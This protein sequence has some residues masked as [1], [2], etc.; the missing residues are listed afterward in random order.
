[1]PRIIAFLL[2]PF[3]FTACQPGSTAEDQA[4]EIDGAGVA[5]ANPPAEGFNEAAS[6]EKAMAI[7]DSVMQ[8]M[9]G[10]K[11]WDTTQY[12]SWNFFDIRTL[13]W[14]KQSGDVRIEVPRDSA[15]YLINVNSDQ[16]K[17]A[18]GG[19]EITNADSLAKYVE[20]GKSI[21]INDSYWLFMPFKLKDSGVTLTYVGEDTIQG[22]D[23]AEVLELRFEGVGVTPQNKYQVYVDPND[24]MVTQWAFYPTVEMDTPRFMTPWAEYKNHG[25]LMLSG[26]RGERDITDIEVIETIPEGTFSNLEEFQLLKSS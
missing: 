9:G 17:V 26:D 7:A 23:M 18:M 3:L 6:D 22:G 11:A 5:Y 15:I 2:A 8:A 14:D 12:V 1:M 21:W 10:R 4:T 16:G 24:Y 13:L 25:S 19:E 20:Q